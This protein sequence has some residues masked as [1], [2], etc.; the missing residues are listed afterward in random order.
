[1][2]VH[3]S[4]MSTPRSLCGSSAGF[5]IAV[6][7][8]LLAVDDDAVAVDLDLRREAAVD[9]I[10]AQQV[11]VGLDRAEIVDRHDLDVRAAALDDGAQ[12]V[13]ADATEPVD[14]DL[15]RH[16]CSMCDLR[17]FTLDHARRRFRTV[18]Q[19]AD[20]ASALQSQLIVDT[21]PR[22]DA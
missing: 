21:R 1:M 11:G 10:E 3:S 12:D 5:L 9:G 8:M 4:A 15:H 18:T 16:F 14:G 7:L 13:A 20:A 2:P 19:S 22:R 6:T 17:R